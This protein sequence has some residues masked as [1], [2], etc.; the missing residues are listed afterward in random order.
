MGRLE[1]VRTRGHTRRRRR[2]DQPPAPPAWLR[3]HTAPHPRFR[4]RGH[5]PAE[6]G[7]AQHAVW[8]V[9]SEYPRA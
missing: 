5:S 4:V 7:A 2:A 1:G 6:Q 8:A 9:N 3:P